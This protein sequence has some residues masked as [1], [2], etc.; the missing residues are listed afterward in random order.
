MTFPFIEARSALF[1]N[2]VCGKGPTSALFTITALSTVYSQVSVKDSHTIFNCC[3]IK[4]ATKRSN[5]QKHVLN[6]L[7]NY[8]NIYT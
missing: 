5:K 6:N 8:Y 3:L 2:S 4:N 1:D 7:K